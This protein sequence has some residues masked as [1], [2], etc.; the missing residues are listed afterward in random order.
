MSCRVEAVMIW[1]AAL[2]A[3]A[4]PSYAGKAKPRP[5]T[6]VVVLDVTDGGATQNRA[7][8]L[9]PKGGDCPLLTDLNTLTGTSGTATQNLLNK[10]RESGGTSSRRWISTKG[11][12]VAVFTFRPQ[13]YIL[14]LDIE[15]KGRETQ[16]GSDIAT[17]FKAIATKQSLQESE[18]VTLSKE[19]WGLE[20]SRA[21][22][23]VRAEPDKAQQIV[24]AT[25][26][27]AM[28]GELDSA[29]ARYFVGDLSREDER[30]TMTSAPEPANK[31]TVGKASGKRGAK[32]KGGG[33][34]EDKDGA[35]NKDKGKERD[36]DKTLH[37]A[38]I[39]LT[40]GPAEHWY[41]STSVPL[42]TVR[43]LQYV[44][45][46]GT[47]EPRDKP[48]QFLIGVNYM[49]GDVLSDSRPFPSGLS[50]GLFVGASSKPFESLGFSIAYRLP[51]WSPMGLEFDLVTP[52]WGLIRSTSDRR[53]GSG[54]V[55]RDGRSVYKGV[56]GVSLNLDRVASWLSGK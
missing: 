15:E 3:F 49:V 35:E 41:L 28:V 37:T 53:D 17:L 34:S 22:L 46:T 29:F 20:K 4:V 5:I 51:A 40:T 50:P 39:A 27:L 38:E 23:T 9:D 54:S 48:K 33:G 1:T 42:T 13:S 19:V 52:F 12:S 14:H 11:D 24:A 7:F 45:S 10:I 44:D 21:V 30:S 55:E 47:F 8:V 31:P 26:S 43:E 6:K 32:T 2:V 25:R 18:Q 16:L 56:F 36:K